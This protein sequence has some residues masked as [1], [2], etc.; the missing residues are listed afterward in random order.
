MVKFDFVFTGDLILV[1]TVDDAEC[2]P[3][4]SRQYTRFNTECKPKLIRLAHEYATKCATSG[5]RFDN[6]VEVGLVLRD[7]HFILHD[8]EQV[9]DGK[10]NP[11]NRV[12]FFLDTREDA[13]ERPA[14]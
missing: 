3:G 2:T 4:S 9:I 12:R 14:M 6:T 11:T 8:M 10:G 1:E 13:D 5:E 7:A